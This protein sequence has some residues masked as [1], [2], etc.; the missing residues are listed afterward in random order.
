MFA[1]A[2]ISPAKITICTFKHNPSPYWSLV[3]WH[4]DIIKCQRRINQGR[5]MKKVIWIAVIAI[6]G[7]LA[8]LMW[9]DEDLDPEVE[10]IIAKYSAKPNLDNNAYI[11]LIALGYPDFDYEQAKQDYLQAVKEYK[12]QGVEFANNL[13]LIELLSLEETVDKSFYCNF[14]ESGC[15][16]TLIANRAEIEA[17]LAQFEHI[18]RGF[19]ALTD[20]K[21]FDSLN[22]Y[23]VNYRF[24]TTENLFRLG[25]I[26]V[27]FFIVDGELER[28]LWQFQQLMALQIKF[29][30]QQRFTLPL[31]INIVSLQYFHVPL[32]SEFVKSGNYSWDATIEFLQP[33][34]I[35]I[36]RRNYVLERNFAE[37]HFLSRP[38]FLFGE[39]VDGDW[40]SKVVL[41]ILYK[42]NLT[43]NDRFHSIQPLFNRAKSKSELFIEDVRIKAAQ[44]A[45]SNEVRSE[46]RNNYLYLAKNVRNIFGAILSLVDAPSLM[47]LINDIADAESTKQLLQILILAQSQDLDDVLASEAFVNPFTLTAPYRQDDSIC[48]QAASEVCIDLVFQE[49]QDGMGE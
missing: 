12:E 47:S 41:H 49:I 25:Y 38:T 29:E 39:E 15:F 19:L 4:R 37:L 6:V 44:T 48:Y 33:R 3:Y 8:A 26:Q 21:N 23:V 32:I 28:A 43:S 22:P 16:E 10:A 40:F 9:F 7:L 35:E 1:L 42:P 2:S 24:L 11:H 13:R 5:Y 46:L 20:L 31:V 34:S 30:A 45:F 18:I 17:D 36:I 14:S 27:Y